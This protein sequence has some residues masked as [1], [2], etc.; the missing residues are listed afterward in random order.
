M[1]R[2]FAARGF[3]VC[4]LRDGNCL[5]G[6]TVNCEGIGVTL[7]AAKWDLWHGTLIVNREIVLEECVDGIFTFI[8][9]LL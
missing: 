8:L 1:F 3:G 5:P 2:L 6:W 4:C 9:R 7:F